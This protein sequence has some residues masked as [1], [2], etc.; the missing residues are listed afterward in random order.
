MDIHKFIIN[1]NTLGSIKEND[2]LS[3]LNGI[4]KIS[5]LS[6]FRPII[7]KIT[8]D[9]RSITVIFLKELIYN[10]L[11]NYIKNNMLNIGNIIILKEILSKAIEGLKH[12]RITYYN[13]INNSF[14]I[15]YILLYIN[16][17]L[18]E[19]ETKIVASEI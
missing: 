11:D 12:L 5:H 17:K 4:L 6:F 9:S 15:L 13:D 1:I 8:G 3:I 10:E 19:L 16:G 2:K 18:M 14:E 7:R